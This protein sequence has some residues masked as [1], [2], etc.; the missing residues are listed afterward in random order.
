[1]KSPTPV[2][3]LTFAFIAVKITLVIFAEFVVIAFLL[4][5]G[6]G[7]VHWAGGWA[8]LLLATGSLIPATIAL[9]VHDPGL[10]DARTKLA[11]KGQPGADRL[12]VPA[13]TLM[14]LV[15]AGVAGIDSVRHHWSYVPLALRIVAAAVIPLAT[16]A[17]YLTMRQNPYL[18]T[19]VYVQDDRAHRVVDHGL[20]AVVRHPFYAV[21]IAYQICASLV[22]GSWLSVFV[23][24]I[25]AVMLALRIRVEERYLARELAGYAAY[26]RHTPWRL[27]PGLW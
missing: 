22:L 25:V 12:F 23:A 2:D 14:M 7:T 13:H 18:A 21:T 9:I 24:L 8:F 15:W 17:G 16:W 1:M 19:C 20:Y 26:Q 10:V 5:Y 3:P 11:P 6:A 27:V 4:F